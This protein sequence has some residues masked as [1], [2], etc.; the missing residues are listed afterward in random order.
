MKVKYN[1]N[2]DTRTMEKLPTKEELFEASSYH[3]TDVIAAMNELADKINRR[4]QNHDSDKL[5]DI[6]G[7]YRDVKDTLENDKTFTELPWYINHIKER[8]HRI[9]DEEFSDINLIDIL[10]YLCDIVTCQAARKGSKDMET[11]AESISKIPMN[12][13]YMALINTAFDIMEEIKIV[14]TFAELEEIKQ[15]Q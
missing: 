12:N 4:S 13:L 15:I 5:S 6:D 14:G 7:F 10:E 1:P 8:H 9:H 3:I 2:A 11:V